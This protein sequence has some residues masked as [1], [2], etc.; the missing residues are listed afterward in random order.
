MPFAV[1]LINW[2]IEILILMIVVSSI[3]SWFNPSPRNPVVKLLSAV[4]D[5]LL[6]PIRAI[7]PASS[8]L[9]FSPMVAILILWF[10]QKLVTGGMSN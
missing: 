3:L 8:G 10:L 7:L 9:D 2:G 1:L 4:V 5:P 6:H